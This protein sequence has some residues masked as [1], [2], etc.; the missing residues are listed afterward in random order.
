MVALVLSCL[1][2]ISTWS[3]MAAT[4]ESP[5]T[6][7]TLI[8]NGTFESNL[9]GWTQTGTS[10]WNAAGYVT[11]PSADG[12]RLNQTVNS[13][14]TPGQSYCFE[15]DVKNEG[16][17][18]GYSYLLKWVLDGTQEVTTANVSVNSLVSEWKTI[19]QIIK[20]PETDAKKIQLVIWLRKAYGTEGTSYDN[21]SLRLMTK[22]ELAGNLTMNTLNAKGD[23]PSGYTKN[24]TAGGSATVATGNDAFEGNGIKLQNAANTDTTSVSIL[25]EVPKLQTN[26]HYE[27]LLYFKL[28]ELDAEANGAKLSTT[29]RG[30][31]GGAS[32]HPNAKETEYF[33]ETGYAGWRQMMVYFIDEGVVSATVELAGKGTLYVDH[34]VLRTAEFV[35][36]GDFQGLS[37]DCTPTGW[38]GTA[39]SV[40]TWQAKTPRELVETYNETT[41]TY[42]NAVN[43]L[44]SSDYGRLMMAYDA[45]DCSFTEGATY[46]LS[47][48]VTG[49]RA[50]AGFYLIYGYMTGFDAAPTGVPHY[51]TSGR[52]GRKTFYMIAGN[53]TSRALIAF[54]P[55]SVNP[56]HIDNMAMTEVENSVTFTK[57]D[58]TEA[59][60]VSGGDTITV[61]CVCPVTK[62]I[63]YEIAAESG[64]NTLKI[65]GQKATMAVAVY[66]E[67]NG[68]K[69]L[70]SVQFTEG[71][72]AFV[73]SQTN[74]GEGS[75]AYTGYVPI[76]CEDT[77]T[78]PSGSGKYSVKAMVLDELSNFAPLMKAA[79]LPAAA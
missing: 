35:V 10:T 78:I 69:T 30:Y 13:D 24:T 46:A 41:K 48:D 11:L 76:L 20:V 22:E 54:A 77:V 1:L 21:V 62:P 53:V 61:S 36:N 65:Q 6:N 58:G 51:K 18:Q 67:E 47:V 66:K 43:F 72:A 9:D 3:V 12:M 57:E 27:L 42:E 50:G 79:V 59:V 26:E 8:T 39:P 70:E 34:F 71:Q 15:A 37:A 7:G 29:G 17:S 16:N 5:A 63:A 74:S 14:F 68:T 31:T 32:Q 64:G 33:K 40:T 45:V 75:K 52:E 73:G 38:Q 28:T 55:T 23:F 25:F 60:S 2:L 49:G 44:Y 4:D 56:G 19:R